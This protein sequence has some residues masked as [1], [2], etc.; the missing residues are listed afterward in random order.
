MSTRLWTREQPLPPP[1]SGAPLLR[2]DSASAQLRTTFTFM[3]LS[4]PSLQALIYPSLHPSARPPSFFTV[5]FLPHTAQRSQLP[6]LLPS[7]PA[8]QTSR[9]L[10]GF[11]MRGRLGRTHA[12]ETKQKQIKHGNFERLARNNLP[13][14]LPLDY[15]EN[16][17]AI[18]NREPKTMKHTREKLH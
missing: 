14:E 13:A 9:P 1:D 18:G 4:H 11:M 7:D 2:G 16:G 8:P 17:R 10:G 12:S 3:L 6:P 5:H 15:L